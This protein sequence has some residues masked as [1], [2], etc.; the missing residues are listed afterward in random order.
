MA[1]IIGHDRPEISALGGLSARVQHGRSRFVDKDTVRAAQM[2]F[3][4][5]DDR[6]QVET[7][8]TDPVAEGAAIEVD[9]LPPED[10]G[11]PVERQAIAEFRDDNPGD[12]Q[13]GGQT[14]GHDMLGGMRLRHSLRAAAAGVFRAASDQHAELGGDR[15]GSANSPGDC[16]PEE[17]PAV[18]I[19][20]GE[21]V[22]RTV[23]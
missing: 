1:A 6:H 15:R 18:R 11:L 23:S 7:G 9:P 19:I 16:L 5:I 12:E 4:V 22:P 8:A 17:G 20:V 13:L 10:L 2:G 21:T 3:H 14:A